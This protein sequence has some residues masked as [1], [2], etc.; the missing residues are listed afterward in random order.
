MG[1]QEP[2]TVRNCTKDEGGPFG[3][4]LQGEAPNHLKL[5]WLKAPVVSVEEKAHKMCQVGTKKMS[6]SEPRMTRRN[7][8]SGIRTRVASQSWD[9]LGGYLFTV[10]AVSGV[11]VA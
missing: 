3:V 5:L 10:R 2:K 6:E 11:H 8:K 4:A 1:S 7:V 9:E